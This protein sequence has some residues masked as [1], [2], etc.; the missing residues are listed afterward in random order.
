[1]SIADRWLLPDGIEEL[2]PTQAGRAERLRRQLVDLY[3]T[4]G[5]QLVMPPLVEFTESL[6]INGHH[7]L[8]LQTCRLTDQLSGRLMG[9]RADITPQTARI[10]AHCLKH[11]GVTRLCYAGSV[12]HARPKTALASRSPIQM[13][14]ELYGATGTEADSEVVSLMLATVQAVGMADITLDLGHV[15]ICRELALFAGL[16]AEQQEVLFDI[17]QRKATADLQHFVQT[18]VMDARAAALLLA[19]PALSGG[20]E[21]LVKARAAFAAAP[22][23]VHAAIIELEQ[24]AACLV[25]RSPDVNVY[26]DL[27]ELRGYHY[28]TGAV[29]SVYVSGAGEAIANGG[30]YDDF[31][32]A[33]GRA[34]P[35]SGFSFDLKHLLDLSDDDPVEKMSIW[36][37]LD[38]SAAQWRAIQALRTEGEVV[39]AAGAAEKQPADCL[40]E[41]VRCDDQYTVRVLSAG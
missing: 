39:I 22:A 31:G 23:A 5:Y 32:A 2:L 28:H 14:C 40:R 7:D 9:I 35:A 12:L 29:F 3:A 20:V 4:W 24:L 41:L 33:F 19:L 15:R 6:L 10:D 17:L 27:A 11:E 13:G 18:Y 36:V 21:V 34:R 37:V 26:I 8:D 38:G 1:M 25:Q 16:N 30:R